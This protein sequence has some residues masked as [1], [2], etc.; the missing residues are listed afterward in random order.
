MSK[1]AYGVTVLEIETVLGA[2]AEHE[3]VLSHVRSE[4]QALQQ[5]LGRIQQL[6]AEQESHRAARQVATQRLNE[7]IAESRLLVEALRDTAKSKIGR[8]SERLVQ[9]GVAPQRRRSARKAAAPK[10]EGG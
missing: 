5:V 1:N 7:A 2:V 9:F 10:P 4:H 8:R 6:K 3:A